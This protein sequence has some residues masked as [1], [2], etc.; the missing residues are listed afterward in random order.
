MDN[1]TELYMH[2]GL[3]TM[4]MIPCYNMIFQIYGNIVIKATKR[5]RDLM[6]VFPNDGTNYLSELRIIKNDPCYEAFNTLFDTLTLDTL[7]GG[8]TPD[9]FKNKD[10]FVFINERD[11]LE[12]TLKL[13]KTDDAYYMY[14]SKPITI[15][16]EDKS[17]IDFEPMS[18]VVEIDFDNSQD[19]LIHRAF[20]QLLNDLGKLQG[21]VE[22]YSN[23]QLKRVPTTNI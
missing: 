4:V 17:T 14:I 13:K 18:I 15:N 5:N 19:E 20:K 1:Q 16:N 2:N 10:E 7:N 12:A 6:D 21:S 22:E 23:Y 9:H 11:P 3:C 8:I